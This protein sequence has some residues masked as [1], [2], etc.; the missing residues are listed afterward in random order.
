M[1]LPTALQVLQVLQR[2]T[3]CEVNDCTPSAPNAGGPASTA[4]CFFFLAFDTATARLL[5]PSYPSLCFLVWPKKT[6]PTA[7][8]H[9]HLAAH[10][11]DSGESIHSLCTNRNLHHPRPGIY[12]GQCCL[13]VRPVGSGLRSAPG[14]ASVYKMRLRAD[15]HRSQ[16]TACVRRTK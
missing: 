1:R 16:I 12:N 5:P 7:E 10:P 8:I 3:S 6:A 2:A 14:T 13:K 9:S 4:F 11:Q 15:P